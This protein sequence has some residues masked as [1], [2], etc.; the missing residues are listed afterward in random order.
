MRNS[1]AGNG[2][3]GK[4]ETGEKKKDRGDYEEG[5]YEEEDYEEGDSVAGCLRGRVTERKQRRWCLCCHA[6]ESL[7]IP[8]YVSLSVVCFGHQGLLI[9]FAKVVCVYMLCLFLLWLPG[10]FPANI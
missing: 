7:W 6:E 10:A 3:R 5:D 4:I 1:G 8:R 9:C 2:F